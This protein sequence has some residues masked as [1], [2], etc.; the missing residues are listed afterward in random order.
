MLLLARR[1]SSRWAI[2]LTVALQ[3]IVF[4][5]PVLISTD[6]FSYIAYARMGVVHGD[7]PLSARPD[8]DRGRSGLP[9]RGQRLDE[10]GDRLRAAV[11]AA[12]LSAGA[13][14]VSSGRCGG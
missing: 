10:G 13:A 9:L 14:W 1:I 6:V 11:H 12:L 5:G 3:L 7:Q 4:A 2:A 8:V